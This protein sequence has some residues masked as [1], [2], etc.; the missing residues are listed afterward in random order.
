MKSIQ[1]KR[2]DIIYYLQFIRYDQTHVIR[3]RIHAKKKKEKEKKMLQFN[4]NVKP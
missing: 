3:K 4:V 1:H 2:P